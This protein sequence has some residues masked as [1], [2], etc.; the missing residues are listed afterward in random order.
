MKFNVEQTSNEELARMVTGSDTDAVHVVMVNGE[1][2]KKEILNRKA[3]KFNE[4]VN[5]LQEVSRT[6]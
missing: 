6:N 5:E 4:Q 2:A 1:S 3:D